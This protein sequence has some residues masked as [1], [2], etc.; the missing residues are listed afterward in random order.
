MTTNTNS[1][2]RCTSEHPIPTDREQ[3]LVC[4]G[5][6]C[7]ELSAP[8]PYGG[9]LVIGTALGGT[10]WGAARLPRS[11]GVRLRLLGHRAHPLG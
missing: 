2:F 4:G 7:G 8:A 5:K 11:W 1:I 6:W 9:V 10:D 3:V